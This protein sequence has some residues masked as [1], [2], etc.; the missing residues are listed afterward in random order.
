VGARKS[1]L[2][3]AAVVA[4]T[5]ITAGIRVYTRPDRAGQ[6]LPASGPLHAATAPLPASRAF[7]DL[8]GVQAAGGSVVTGTGEHTVLWHQQGFTLAGEPAQ[9]LFTE[10]QFDAPAE[11]PSISAATYRLADGQWKLAGAS[12]DFTR[13]G[14]WGKL[15]QP[16]GPLQ[17]LQ[18][19]SG[20]V[21]FLV[22]ASSGER[23]YTQSGKGI[24]A[25]ANGEWR[26]L[27]F[28]QTGGDN[29]AA[30]QARGERY[31]FS[32]VISMAAGTR[33]WPDLLVARSGTIRDERDR[34]VPATD[35]RYVFTGKGYEEVLPRR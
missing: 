3:T 28:V 9:V 33:T 13:T 17:V 4:A 12:K 26:D 2:I 16:R 1:G 18:F 29:A 31:H 10:T 22:D 34:V 24:W 21:A 30:A 20:T 6:P 32:G 5:F 27:G 11:A 35:T 8:F 19:P 25:F 23:G 14:A 7:S 15:P